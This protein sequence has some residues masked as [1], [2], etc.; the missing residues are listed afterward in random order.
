MI[1]GWSAG[2]TIFRE[3]IC[4]GGGGHADVYLLVLLK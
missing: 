4:W 3:D 2:D 1:E